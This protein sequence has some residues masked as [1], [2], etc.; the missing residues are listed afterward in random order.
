MLE[1]I[2]KGIETQLRVQVP[3]L[4]LKTYHGELRE[5]FHQ[6]WDELLTS[7][8]FVAGPQLQKF[9]Q[10][11]S[12]YC[13]TRHTIG[14]ANGTDAITL[15]LKALGIGPGDEVITPVNSFVATA[16]GIMHTGARPVFVD[17]DPRTYNIDV[18]RIESLIT[19]RTRAILPVHLYGQPADMDPILEIATAHRLWVVEDSAQAH[20]ALYRGR[21]AGSL[22]HAACFSFY[23]GKNLGACGYGGAIVTSDGQIASAI[24][25]L[26]DHGGVRKYEHDLVGYNSR[27]DSLQA[28][29]LDVKLRHLD[30][31]NRLRRLHAAGYCAMLSAIPGVILPFE[32]EGVESVYHLYVVQL[33][34]GSREALQSYLADRGV[35][36]GIHYPAPIH[37]TPAFAAWRGQHCPVAERLSPRILSLPMFPE[38]K[39]SQIEYVAELIGDFM[40]RG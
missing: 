18:N 24:R 1:V 27:L 19:S 16:E 25:K 32:L 22:G 23:P 35:Q 26:R 14:V 12:E 28:A 40:Q 20:G 38:L 15:A 30:E 11:F 2:G 8:A 5:K 33:E 17:V 36:T 21:K 31:R 37:W 6:I 34:R 7:A 29:I 3:F 4:D 13:Q 10:D 39:R 9:E